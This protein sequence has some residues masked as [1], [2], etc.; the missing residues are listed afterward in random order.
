MKN[1]IVFLFFIL[2][3]NSLWAVTYSEAMSNYQGK[4]FE[5]AHKQ[6]TEL[7]SL[8]NKDAQ[9]LLGVMYLNGDGIKSDIYKAFAWM[10]LAAS[11]GDKDYKKSVDTFANKL[12]SERL[13]KARSILDELQKTYGDETIEQKMHPVLTKS[14]QGEFQQLKLKYKAPT[15][16]PKRAQKTGVAAG[17][18]LL[19]Y[20]VGPDGRT[21]HHRVISSTSKFFREEAL[22]SVK[23]YQYHPATI[24]GK[25]VETYLVVNNFTFEI[26]GF[27]ADSKAL[28]KKS[29]EMKKLA[30][31][32]SSVD[33]Y[34]YAQWTGALKRF[35][36]PEHRKD[37]GNSNEWY[38]LS[39]IDGLPNA[40]FRI[41]RNMLYGEQCEA[42]S[43][44]SFFWLQLAAENGFAEAQTLLGLERYKGVRFDRDRKMGVAWL[45]KAAA[46]NH[47][48]AMVELAL[49]Y[50]MSD[51]A[52]IR[53]PQ[54]ALAIIDSI[55]QKMEDRLTYYESLAAVY[56]INQEYEKAEKSQK[57]LLKE[58]KKHRLPTEV[59]ERNLNLIKNKKAI[60]SLI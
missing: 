2:A 6:F 18:V 21:K 55:P 41:G 10:S 13:E 32:G 52:G 8:G 45:E 28:H 5:R 39:A 59:F 53:D 22:R 12:D 7:A 31:K 26:E 40:Q 25:P 4:N 14:T 24:N 47:T 1:L 42:D 29:M 50:A 34:K 36:T 58:A 60:V 46:Q 35:M 43:D 54:K 30:L 51:D 16:Y 27:E 20:N 37:L 19:E 33:R 49:I 38:T 44:K 23:A 9:Y 17:S 11:K 48:P 56:S 15:Y 57:R 3:C